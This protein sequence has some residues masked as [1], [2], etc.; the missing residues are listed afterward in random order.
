M[1]PDVPAF[2]ADESDDELVPGLLAG[3]AEPSS[4]QATPCPV[5]TAVPTP[6]ATASP[7]TRPMLDAALI[8]LLSIEVPVRR[9]PLI[10]IE[11]AGHGQC[12][13]LPTR[14]MRPCRAVL[15]QPWFQ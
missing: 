14:Y 10:N 9:N 12:R 4:A 5:R 7:P 6:S 8:A 13:R 15:S 2:G 1:P 11:K 3:P